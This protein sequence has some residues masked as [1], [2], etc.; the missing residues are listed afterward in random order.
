MNGLYNSSDRSGLYVGLFCLIQDFLNNMQLQPKELLSCLQHTFET[1]DFTFPLPLKKDK[2]SKSDY[3]QNFLVSVNCSKLLCRGA[4]LIEDY[5]LT[6]MWLKITENKDSYSPS[7]IRG[8]AWHLHLRRRWNVTKGYDLSTLNMN[9][10]VFNT[11]RITWSCEISQVW[12][13]FTR[14]SL[15]VCLFVLAS[16]WQFIS[17]K[18]WPDD[19]DS[20]SLHMCLSEPL[21]HVQ[22]I[23]SLHSKG[24]DKL[25]WFWPLGTGSTWGDKHARAW[26]ICGD[27]IHR[28]GFFNIQRILS[29]I[30]FLCYN[31][32]TNR[33]NHLNFQIS[34]NHQ[35]FE[36]VFYPYIYV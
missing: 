5:L 32:K 4:L 2:T 35:I 30:Y 8:N 11:Q 22:R 17:L 28:C 20:V 16:Y 15:I 19:S 23:K 9:Q 14:Q 6:L 7:H 25:S 33:G 36:R 27:K 1:V 31:L 26:L 12:S 24:Y 3:G 13:L 18:R 10:H 29:F 21:N 34:F